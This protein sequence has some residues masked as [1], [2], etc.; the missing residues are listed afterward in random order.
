MTPLIL[1]LFTLTNQSI[2]THKLAYSADLAARAQTRA[3]YL[4]EKKQ[5]SHDGWIDSF[6]GKPGYIGE[7]LAKLPKKKRE[8]DRVYARKIHKALMASPTHRA[9]II[10][11]RYSEVGIG[12]DCDITVYLYW[13]KK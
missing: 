6:I 13:G 3:E 2:D 11:P 8:S 5:W 12:R 7:N 1:I 10:N 4:C 9:N